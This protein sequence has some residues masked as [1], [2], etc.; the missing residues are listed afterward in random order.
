MKTIEIKN[1][2]ELQLNWGATVV[3]F[4]IYETMLLPKSK[5]PDSPLIDSGRIQIRIGNT[6]LAL[7]VQSA[8]FRTLEEQDLYLN[9][10]VK[11]TGTLVN[12]A[13]LWGYPD[14]QSIIMPALLNI[15]QIERE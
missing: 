2:S 4:G 5:R 8:G 3:V 10:K 14:E 6:R 11:V 12:W 1:E 13:Q 9:Q 7:E 15:Q